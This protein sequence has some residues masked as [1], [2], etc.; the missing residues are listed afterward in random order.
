MSRT[1]GLVCKNENQYID[2]GIDFGFWFAILYDK[3][4]DEPVIWHDRI[5]QGNLIEFL[6]KY[7]DLEDQRNKKTIDLVCLDLDPADHGA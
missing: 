2:M 7:L 4:Q 6:H 3:R 1:C 5:S